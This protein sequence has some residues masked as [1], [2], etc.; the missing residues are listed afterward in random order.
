M[1]RPKGWFGASVILVLV[2]FGAWYAMRLQA[3]PGPA[4]AAPAIPVTAKRARLQDVP[5]FLDGLGTV[6]PFNRVM[7]HVRVD[8]ELREVDFTEGQD[9]KQ[10]DILARIDPRPF[11]AQL[12]QATAAKAR[13]EAQLANAKLNLNRDTALVA[14]DYAT[15]QTVDTEKALVAQL[16]ATV[17]GDEATIENA[18]TQL[19]YTT[20]A[21]PLDGRT[22]VRM[23]DRG[24]I[25]HASDPS[26][27]VLITQVHPIAVLFSLSEDHLQPITSAMK[28]GRLKVFAYSRDDRTKIAEGTLTLVDNQIDTSTGMVP[29]KAVFPNDEDALWPGEFVHAHLQLELRTNAITV[30]AEAIQRGPNDLYVY[31]VKPNST[32]EQRRVTVGP[33]HDDVAVIDKGLRAGENVVTDGQFKLKPGARIAVTTLPAEP[34]PSS[35][36]VAVDRASLAP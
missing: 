7:V 15:R 19:S 18:Q 24:N 17:R 30:P 8:G 2:A 11:Q 26:G 27:L 21:S 31:V 25:V 28:A 9:V 10:G 16:E 6:V 3:H 4:R 33:V 22:G 36:Q 23:I 29:L 34:P 1:I 5:V 13:D 32:V 20:I 12:D 35:A 14:K